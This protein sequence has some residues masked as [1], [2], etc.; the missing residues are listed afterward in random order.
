MGMIIFSML[1][2]DQVILL[3]ALILCL[4]NKNEASGKNGD[5][6]KKFIKPGLLRIGKIRLKAFLNAEF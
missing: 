1:K 2:A 5:I 4:H 6:V 3:L